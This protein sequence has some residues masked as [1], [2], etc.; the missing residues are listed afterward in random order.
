M[1]T[2]AKAVAI[3]LSLVAVMGIT[4]YTLDSNLQAGVYPTDADSIAIPLFETASSL[5]VILVPLTLAFLFTSFKFFRKRILLFIGAFLYLGGAGLAALLA[6]SWFT[7]HHYG[8][9]AAYAFLAAVALAL[10]VLALRK[11]PSN[12]AVKRDALDARP[13]L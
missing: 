2:F 10:A 3:L 13:L 12:P 9:S 5:V 1:R 4:I 7:P 8:I 11:P 6:L